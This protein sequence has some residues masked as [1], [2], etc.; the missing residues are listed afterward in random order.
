[1]TTIN[2][3]FRNDDRVLTTEELDVVTGGNTNTALLD[4]ALVYAA[5]AQM[6]VTTVVVRQAAGLH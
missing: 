4:K 6:Y 1:M 5:I 2:H 3:E